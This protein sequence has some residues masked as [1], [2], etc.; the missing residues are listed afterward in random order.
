MCGRVIDL[1]TGSEIRR[2]DDWACS[3]DG[4]YVSPDA[5]TL[6]AHGSD[7]VVLYDLKSGKTI[8]KNKEFGTNS[9]FAVSP[10]FSKYVSG[11]SS[12]RIVYSIPENK[13]LYSLKMSNAETVLFSPDSSKILAISWDPAAYLFDTK[14]GRVIHKFEYTEDETW[15]PDC[16][17]LGDGSH[18]FVTLKN[19][20]IEI[21]ET[22][23]GEKTNVV[24]LP[25]LPK[26]D[27]IF[28][29]PH[30]SFFVAY[31]YLKKI[32]AIDWKTGEITRTDQLGEKQFSCFRCDLERN[33]IYYGGNDGG[34][35]VMDT[36]I[37]KWSHTIEELSWKV[38]SL[39]LSPDGSRLGVQHANGVEIFETENFGRICTL[40]IKCDPESRTFSGVFFS[41]D[42]KYACNREYSYLRIF[43][44]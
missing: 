1:K 3:P 22:E 23:S 4:L 16:G 32:F 37:W 21:R 29:S 38:N 9:G 18:F 7:M 34:I 28:A 24:K 12:S 30:G 43:G 17:F 19:N 10:D 25:Y 20:R 15:M 2:L 8:G 14:K 40:D 35:Y 39:H 6:L 33:R 11:T 42:W 41:P 44:M 27:S 26:H 13:K 5:S 31:Q 36:S